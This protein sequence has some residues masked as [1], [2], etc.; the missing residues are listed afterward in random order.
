MGSKRKRDE[1]SP[2]RKRATQSTNITTSVKLTELKAIIENGLKN[3]PM[4]MAARQYLSNTKGEIDIDQLVKLLDESSAQPKSEK[5]LKALTERGE[6]MPDFLTVRDINDSCLEC[7]LDSNKHAVYVLTITLPKTIYN[8]MKNHPKFRKWKIMKKAHVDGEFVYLKGKIGETTNFYN[9]SKSYYKK[10]YSNEKN[11]LSRVLAYLKTQDETS[12]ERQFREWVRIWPILSGKNMNTEEETI[13]METFCSFL[14]GPKG[15]SGYYYVGRVHNLTTEAKRENGE[16]LIKYG[17]KLVKRP[18]EAMITRHQLNAIRLNKLMLEM[19]EG[20]DGTMITRNQLN[21]IRLNELMSEMIE[22]PDGTMITRN[23]LNGKSLSKLMSEMIEGPG[24]EMVKRR[25]I[26]V[27][28]M[29]EQRRQSICRSDGVVRTGFQ[30]G[31]V[32]RNSNDSEEAKNTIDAFVKRTNIYQKPGYEE[33]RVI[34]ACA[35]KIP[36]LCCYGLSC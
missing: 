12:G 14:I 36:N 30:Q 32:T 19:V 8:N 2:V 15:N 18:G 4:K 33:P 7:T 17:K 24:G 34:L 11:P 20:P 31:M 22:G 5:L 16:R 21:A 35:S 25:T 9:R 3:H 10:N 13:K 23:Q 29:V 27:K 1:A 26:A 28:N 6:N